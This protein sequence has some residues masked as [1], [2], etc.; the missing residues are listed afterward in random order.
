LATEDADQRLRSEAMEAACQQSFQ[1]HPNSSEDQLRNI[2]AEFK[3]QVEQVESRLNHNLF[4][5]I[6]AVEESCRGHYAT[7]KSSIHETR[8]ELDSLKQSP[9][10]TQVLKDDFRDD[11]S[12]HSCL[13]SS[14][15]RC[16]S[17]SGDGPTK[18]AGSAEHV[19]LAAC[20]GELDAELRLE[21]KQSINSLSDV[22]HSEIK[23]QI[24]KLEG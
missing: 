6:D 22:L 16:E 8:S 11:S 3:I 9:L 1:Q 18:R 5:K 23:Q 7:L 17:V 21:L 24:A 2:S 15:S 20:V 14:C 10:T 4:R 12:M 19:A 13:P